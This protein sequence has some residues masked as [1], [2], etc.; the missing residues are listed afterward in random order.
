MADPECFDADPDPNF[1]ADADPDPNFQYLGRERRKQILQNL[2]LMFPTS[3]H[4]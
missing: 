1:Y 3:C 2:Q 4:V